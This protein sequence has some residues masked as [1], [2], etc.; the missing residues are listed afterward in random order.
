MTEHGSA[1]EAEAR[2][3][4]GAGA[5]PV[6][7]CG[8]LAARVP[9]WVEA[10]LAVGRALG[11][12]EAELRRRLAGEP[13]LLAELRPGEEDLYAAALE[14]MGVFDVPLRLDAREAAVVEHLHA[15]LRAQGGLGSGYYHGIQRAFAKG[16]SAQIFRSLVRFGPRRGPRH[17]GRPTEFWT[18]LTAAGELLDP[19]DGDDRGTVAQGLDTCRERLAACVDQ[20]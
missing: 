13:Q 1:L 4:L 20:P 10:A 18:A 17:A 12:E 2:E 3:R 8:V 11:V 14:Q 9:Q 7:V 19:A 6:E 16:E 15:A 5:D